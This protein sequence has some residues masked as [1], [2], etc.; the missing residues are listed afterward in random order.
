[1][2][3]LDLAL[4]E[5]FITADHVANFEKGAAGVR[6]ALDRGVSLIAL[7]ELWVTGFARTRITDFLKEG[8]THGIDGVVE[9]E[10]MCRQRGADL[11]YGYPER[12]TNHLFFNSLRIPAQPQPRAYRKLMVYVDVEKN[13]VSAKASSDNLLAFL[14][15]NCRAENFIISVQL[16]A[17][18]R[19]PE[20]A[21]AGAQL[22]ACLILNCS[23]WRARPRTSEGGPAHP[24]HW[25]WL[26][27]ARAI[28]NQ[29][30]VAGCGA[31]GTAFA[32]DLLG[33]SGVYDPLGKKVRPIADVPIEGLAEAGRV[34]FYK[35]DM[36]RVGEDAD[37]QADHFIP[38]IEEM[39][40]VIER[41]Q[42][43]TRAFLGSA[44][45]QMRAGHVRYDVFLSYAASDDSSAR[46]LV[47]R[48]ENQGL[49]VFFAPKSLQFGTNFSEE[50]R[51]ALM[52]SRELWL[53]MTPQVVGSEWVTTEWGA[54]W[55]LRK[56]IVPILL[57]VSPSQ[58][59][60]RLREVQAVDYHDVEN[61]L[62]Q[63]LARRENL[64]LDG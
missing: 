55:A 50:I 34:L 28:E 14:H 31:T 7:P 16:C 43:G 36:S 1:M 2:G 4:I 29:V 8:V 24:K 3:K 40:P 30:Y 46:A 64:E 11:V 19:F 51:S 38:W 60:E 18:L 12:A 33:E 35:L 63:S 39:A 56:L 44:A 57:R 6:Q 5:P 32:Y 47:Q 13:F 22:G 41:V 59:P 61:L 15:A 25:Q 49:T 52:S 23:Q 62:S 58:L 21:R 10:T 45:R 27:R 17:D 42:H 53:L 20:I 26:L 54:A 37:P 48:A 9:L